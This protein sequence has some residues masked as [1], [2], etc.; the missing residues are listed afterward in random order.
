MTRHERYAAALHLFFLAKDQYL[1][2]ST[3]CQFKGS[4]HF[5]LKE[6]HEEGP[7]DGHA[8]GLPWSAGFSEMEESQPDQHCRTCCN[9]EK[10]II[11]D[12]LDVTVTLT[13]KNGRKDSRNRDQGPG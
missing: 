3:R 5:G 6:V 4:T 9:K 8:E 1:S 12:H 11:E 7:A 2:T 13:Y 10:A